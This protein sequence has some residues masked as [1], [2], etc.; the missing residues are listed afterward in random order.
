MRISGMN[1]LGLL[2][3]AVVLSAC[4]GSGGTNVAEGGIGG[5]GMS[6]GVVTKV[7]SVTVNGVEFSTEGAQI[8]TDEVNAT[9]TTGQ[10]VLE[11]N[12]ISEGMV[13]FVEGDINP[14]GVTGTATRVTYLDSLEGPLQAAPACN[15]LMVLGQNVVVDDQTVFDGVSLGTDG[16]LTGLSVGN[17]VE[18]SGLVTANGTLRASYLKKQSELWSPGDELELKGIV[19]NLTAGGFTIWGQDVDTTTLVGLTLVEGDYVE[20]VGTDFSATGALLASSVEVVS[21]GGDDVAEAEFEGIITAIDTSAKQLV[22]GGVTT[23]DY[24]NAEFDGGGELDL[25]I[26]LRIEAE[27]AI[28]NRVLVA[29]EIEFE[30]SIE[31]VGL[32]STDGVDTLTLMGTG[33]QV[34]VNDATAEIGGGSLSGFADITT[35]DSLEVRARS[36]AGGYVASRVEWQDPVSPGDPIP[37]SISG[38]LDDWLQGTSISSITLLGIYIEI[39][40]LSIK[41]E[42][43]QAMTLEEFYAA[44]DAAQAAIVEVKGE[45]I[46]GMPVWS[47][48]E[49]DE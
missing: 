46:S 30:D 25:A 23:V 9:D 26:G 10:L 47:E 32:F 13:I 43:E 1:Y 42:W 20:V 7:G 18:A 12:W 36:S 5:T 33:L 27:G 16:C 24:T 21:L 3:A 17:V 38:P 28:A 41:D 49:L 14:D 44:L 37:I 6:V 48:L 8:I 15:S 4:G 29:D 22:L 19:S 11:N 35:G 39:Q 31:L 2:L 45:L 34:R 40:D